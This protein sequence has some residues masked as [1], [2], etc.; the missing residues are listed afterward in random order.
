MQRIC[1]TFNDV[2]T[3]V[4]DLAAIGLANQRC[5]SMRWQKVAQWAAETTI[6]EEGCGADS[7]EYAAL[8]AQCYQLFQCIES[9]QVPDLYS[10]NTL[11]GWVNQI[12]DSNL[13]FSRFG[14]ISSGSTGKQKAVVHGADKLLQEVDEL[15]EI[16]SDARRVV[17]L[18]P[19]CHL[20]GFIFTLLLPQKLQIPLVDAKAKSP[21]EFLRSLQP[22][23]LVVG[24]P[25]YWR[26][27]EILGVDF[28][29]DIT[30]V[31][32]TAPAADTLINSLCELGTAAFIE[33]YGATETGGIGYRRWPQKN[34]ELFNYWQAET[35]NETASFDLSIK[36]SNEQ[37]S[38]PDVITWLGD[39]RFSIGARADGAVQV[40]GINVSLME[41]ED[42]LVR[43]PSVESCA[44]RKMGELEGS[45]L[46]A[47]IVSVNELSGTER[48]ELIA[49]LELWV[50]D[51]LKPVQR[52]KHFTIGRS[53]PKNSMGK[54]CDW[55][56]VEK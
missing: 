54:S 13:H 3:L 22:G 11:G 55:A 40:G 53:I 52:P 30:V 10:V 51:N 28:P 17:S 44:V 46:K 12:L 38:L 43:H 16:F 34:Y 47:Y 45:R 37:Y 39:R 35:E 50:K 32:S 21:V 27:L 8:T 25:D 31:S 6:D 14:F 26:H 18:V 24:Y 36:D 23:D 33:I 42:C 49:S 7:L 4:R 19:S 15:A 20:Y 48:L 29:N 41:V 56:I 1:L 2:L 5:T 9:E